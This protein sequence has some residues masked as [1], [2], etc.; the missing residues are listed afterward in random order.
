[1]E[2][3]GRK[4]KAPSGNIGLE[5][6]PFLLSNPLRLKMIF[7]QLIPAGADNAVHTQASKR[8]AA[9]LYTY[10]QYNLTQIPAMGLF[11]MNCLPANV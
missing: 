2:G 5:T 11:L 7:T 8:P 3:I 1:M 4:R 9:Q 6:P 10:E